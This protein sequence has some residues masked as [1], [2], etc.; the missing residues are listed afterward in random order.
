MRRIGVFE[1]FILLLGISLFVACEKEES[2]DEDY[3]MDEI[4]VG[5]AMDRLTQIKASDLGSSIRYVP[6][7]TTKQSELGAL[8]RIKLTDDYLFILS[9]GENVKM[10]D[11]QTGKYIRTIGTLND[12]LTA[13][14]NLY[15]MLS[16]WVDEP[17]QAIYLE[18]HP[19]ELVQYGFDGEYK[20][21]FEV[22]DSIHADNTELI[23]YNIRFDTIDAY[24]RSRI[25]YRP[26]RLYRTLSD[27]TVK[28]AYLTKYNPPPAGWKRRAEYDE[29]VLGTYTKFGGHYRRIGYDKRS[30]YFIKDAPMLWTFDG[31]IRFKED[32]V[33]TIYNVT[34]DGLQPFLTFDLG[35]WDWPFDER[36]LINR[37]VHRLAIDYVLEGDKTVYFHFHE[38]LYGYGTYRKPYCGVYDKQTG[39]TKAMRGDT[40]RNDITHLMPF[41]LQGSANGAYCAVIEAW[42][43]K[44]W[45]DRNKD[46]LDS[47]TKNLFKGLKEH[48]NPIVVI[49]E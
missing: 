14:N 28:R 48:D 26:R 15:R 29:V 8:P 7:E 39:Y 42:E 5:R 30:F 40:I 6:L 12:S 47:H 27:G 46:T 17:S 41:V 20:R 18:G 32:F 4:T 37:C 31:N 25:S 49:I 11:R 1:I 38:G 21:R 36:Y 34:N 2:L 9:R 10:F 22:H 23:Y 24:S 35:K 16:C 13:Y 3:N 19:G 45:V 43:V 33:N 44:D